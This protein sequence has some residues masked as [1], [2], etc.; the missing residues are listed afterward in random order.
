[1]KKLMLPI[2][3]LTSLSL[4]CVAATSPNSSLDEDI[5]LQVSQYIAQSWDTLTRKCNSF[6]SKSS[7]IIYI[8][9]DEDIHKIKLAITQNLSKEQAKQIDI[10]YLPQDVSRIKEHGLLYLPY[11]YSVH[12]A[13]VPGQFFQGQCGSP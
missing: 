7:V 2:A 4:S 1:M 6:Y 12:T 11:P 9:R 5:G 8:P 3:M 13:L 10:R